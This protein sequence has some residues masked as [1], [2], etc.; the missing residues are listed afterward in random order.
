ME[1]AVFPGPLC[2]VSGMRPLNPVFAGLP[3][4]IF[5]VMSALAVEH[6]A[7]NLGQGFPDRDGPEE[8]RAVAAEALRKGPNQYPPMAGVA[9]LRQAI[10]AHALAHYRISYD[11]DGEV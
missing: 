9:E 3:T 2:N 4:T 7:I 11:P 10:A 1:L 5:T 8:I 6:K